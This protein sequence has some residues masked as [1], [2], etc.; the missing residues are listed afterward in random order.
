MK[1]ETASWIFK[2]ALIIIG[3][4]AVI[5]MVSC[6][7]ED[8]IEDPIA[9]FQY[10]ISEDNF[11][12]VTFMNF[13]LNAETY[14]WNFGDGNTSAEMN[15]THTFAEVG[16][17]TVQLTATNSVG[18]VAN[19]SET[20][21]IKDPFEALTLLAGQTSKTWRLYRVG[22]SMGVGPNVDDPRSWWA[23]ENDGKRPCVYNHEFTFNR[24]GQFIFN[25]MGAFWGEE[26]I[27]AVPQKATCFEATASNMV[28]S[29]GADVSA[30]LSGTHAFEYNPST[31]MVTL[32]GVG[33]W[34]GLPQLTTSGDQITPVA[35][36][37]FKIT[38]EEHDGYDLMKVLYVYEWGVWEFSYASYSNPALEPEVVSFMVDFSFE[39]VGRTV[40]FENNSKDAVSYTWNFGDGNT[41]TQENPTHTYAADGTY[42]VVLTGKSSTGESKETT[43]TVAID[44]STLTDAPPTPTE[45][46]ANVIS[47]YS[48]AYTNITGVNINPA[49]G[50]A[51]VTEEIEVA[52]KKVLKMAGLNY[53]GIDFAGNAQDVSGKTKLHVDVWCSGVTDVN[54]SV[55]SPG[56]EN[57]VKVTT[58]AG[59]WKSFD[60]LLSGYTVPNLKEVIQLKFDDAGSGAS[61][62]I[63]VAN[64]FFY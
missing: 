7:D 59:V 45:P 10:E 44:T 29:E 57:A 41:S 48:E 32:T 60:I 18:I 5:A 21:E 40:T 20:I 8:P 1:K 30:W 49:W 31:N 51:T 22:T 17:Y 36:K 15:P 39:V 53:Q 2:H 42:S 35:S 4:F 63:Y 13:S 54:L 58:E 38:I 14:A 28:N 47:I 11:L 34:M 50:Q 6:K 62:T 19:F 52:G 16:E 27:F 9:S 33:A 64:I 23:L 61:P 37:S 43:K 26:A 55:I 12:Q 46:A 25:D 3:L 56:K 24:Q